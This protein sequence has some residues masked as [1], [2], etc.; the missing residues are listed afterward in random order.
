MDVT[1][2]LSI[3]WSLKKP[4]WSLSHKTAANK[5]DIYEGVKVALTEYSLQGGDGRRFEVLSNVCV[6]NETSNSANETYLLLRVIQ[7]CYWMCYCSLAKEK[8]LGSYVSL[9]ETRDKT[10]EKA[11]NLN[12]IFLFFCTGPDTGINFLK[13][14]KI[15]RMN[16]R[17]KGSIQW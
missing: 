7:R 16:L 13:S 8:S 3:S 17:S 14:T 4:S 12:H 5:R 9:N 2:K 1:W 6:S 15:K 11:F 10:L